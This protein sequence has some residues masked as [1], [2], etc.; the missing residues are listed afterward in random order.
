MTFA[1]HHYLTDLS[2]A[3]D[4]HLLVI[5]PWINKMMSLLEWNTGSME[6]GRE[7]CILYMEYWLYGVQER[8]MYTC[9]LLYKF[10][11]TSNE[12]SCKTE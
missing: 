7:E 5:I 2:I 11:E 3:T 4:L 9:V 6:Y 10:F 8:G 12:E 1:F